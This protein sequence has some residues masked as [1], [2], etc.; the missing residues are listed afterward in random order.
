MPRVWPGSSSKLLCLQKRSPPSVSVLQV[1]IHMAPSRAE[2]ASM[3]RGAAEPSHHERFMAQM[4][5]V[6]AE[7]AAEGATA[8]PPQSRAASAA[9]SRA[10]SEVGGAS[11]ASL[12]SAADLAE[13]SEEDRLLAEATFGLGIRDDDDEGWVCASGQRGKIWGEPEGF[14]H[15]HRPAGSFVL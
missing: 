4:L 12:P 1:G 10:A 11:L 13:A 9:P 7:P 14:P 8:A 6:G 3:R 2:I 5:S 15:W